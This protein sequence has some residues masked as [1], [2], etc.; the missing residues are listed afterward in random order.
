MTDPLSTVER[1]HAALRT[2]LG[3]DEALQAEFRESAAEFFGTRTEWSA[4]AAPLAERRHLEWFLLERE[5]AHLGGV[6]I[7]VLSARADAGERGLGASEAAAWV[8]SFC[9]VFE[10]TGV[11]PGEGLWVRDLAGSGEYPL[12]EPEASQVLEPGDLLAGRIFPA[13]DSVFGASP[14]A[15]FF[16]DARLLEALRADI[17]KARERTRGVLRIAQ[18]EIEALFHRPRNTAEPE[19]ALSQLRALLARGGMAAEEIELVLEEL[20]DSPFDPEALT[21]GAGD[22]LGEI[23]DQ[24]AFET[25]LDLDEARRALLAAWQALA[26]R[27][28]GSGS[29]LRPAA[30][31]LPRAGGEPTEL[32][33]RGKAA[34]A[35]AEFDRARASGR[36]LEQ[37]FEALEKALELDSESDADENTPAPDFPGAIAA[38][39]EEFLWELE[40]T[41]GARAARDCALLRSLGRYAEPIGVSENLGARQLA[42]FS[43]RWLIDQDELE[44]ADEARALVSALERFRRWSEESHALALG[45]GTQELL[46]QLDRELPR[47]VEANRRRTRRADV[48]EGEVFVL[49]SLADGMAEVRGP[50]AEARVAI[51]ALLAEWLRPGDRLRGRLNQGRLAVYACYPELR[52]PS[53]PADDSATEEA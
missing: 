51:D 22:I 19:E 18:R 42:E 12:G 3:R 43:A 27:G 39:V 26:E 47:I 52:L 24:L 46:R 34:E 45:A 7:Q 2:F 21:P 33:R 11:R 41:E 37:S 29:S 1:G 8:G 4:D 17:D 10:V 32:A 40:S 20:A 36:S 28:P 23:L 25:D 6:P 38:L 53:V 5:S 16:R 30:A 35:L 15:V 31:P 49:L 50:D 44:G 13:G 9:G 14:A 48:A